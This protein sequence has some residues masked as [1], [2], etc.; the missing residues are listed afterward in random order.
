ML[1]LLLIL[2]GFGVVAVGIIAYTI[3]YS[4]VGKVE[5]SR[6]GGCFQATRDMILPKNPTSAY[7]SGVMDMMQHPGYLYE[8]DPYRIES[9]DPGYAVK[10]GD[11]IKLVAAYEHFSFHTSRERYLQFDLDG[12]STLDAPLLFVESGEC[13]RGKKYNVSVCFDDVSFFKPAACEDS[14]RNRAMSKFIEFD[15]VTENEGVPTGKKTS[16]VALKIRTQVDG[17]LVVFPPN[18]GM[19]LIPDKVPQLINA[20]TPAVVFVRGKPWDAS[21]VPQSG[22]GG[23]GPLRACVLAT[24]EQALKIIANPQYLTLNN[25]KQY[26]GIP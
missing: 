11:I 21:L 14:A 13:S 22:R 26:H 8:I 6:M 18:S 4:S 1:K 25:L 7:Q 15:W 16:N 19:Q 24:E 5:D 3:F 20:H 2:F 9:S 10:K 23:G 12:Q 17:F